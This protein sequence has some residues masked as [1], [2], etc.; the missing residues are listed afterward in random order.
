M[1]FRRKISSALICACLSLGAYAQ[2]IMDYIK[3]DG[4][5]VDDTPLGFQSAKDALDKISKDPSFVRGGSPQMEATGIDQY[6]KKSER[7]TFWWAFGPKSGFYPALVRRRVVNLDGYAEVRTAILCS[8]SKQACD[9][10]R[11]RFDAMDHVC[12]MALPACKH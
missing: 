3:Q 8:A 10:I 1:E 6:S 7:W 12:G 5:I 4:L 11:A 9:E 2:E